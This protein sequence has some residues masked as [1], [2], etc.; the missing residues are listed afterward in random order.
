MPDVLRAR[1]RS[2]ERIAMLLTRRME[3]GGCQTLY[4]SRGLRELRRWTIPWKRPPKEKK[5][6]AI[7]A[8]RLADRDL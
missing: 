5:R 3:T 2:S 7:V 4:G 1:K 8:V 6:V